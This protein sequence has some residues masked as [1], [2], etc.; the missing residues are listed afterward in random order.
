M[1]FWIIF[2]SSK[3]KPYHIECRGDSGQLFLLDDVF[4]AINGLVGEVD[5]FVIA[6]LE[7]LWQ[8]EDDREYD[9]DDNAKQKRL[10]WHGL[11]KQLIVEK[12]L[13]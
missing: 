8:V 9:D 7:E 5:E 1:F 13:K 11:E 12:L 10:P 6:V 3:W 2:L 4:G